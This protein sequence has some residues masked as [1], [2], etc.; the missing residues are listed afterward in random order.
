LLDYVRL[1]EDL[2]PPHWRP[3]FGP[4]WNAG[5]ETTAYFLAWIE[6]KFG[7]DKIKLLN[8]K[9]NTEKYND[10][11][12]QGLV[13]V[14]ITE[15][16]ATYCESMDEAAATDWS[17]ELSE[18]LNATAPLPGWP[19]PKLSIKVVDLAHEGVSVFF[20]AVNPKQALEEA[21]LA[22]FETLYTLSNVPTKYV[23]ELSSLYC[24][25]ILNLSGQCEG[26]SSC[27]SVYGWC[28]PH[29]GELVA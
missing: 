24:I 11:I 9:L 10:S 5:Y 25:L 26:D 4:N 16:W 20:G 7:A 3:S 23:F 8:Q 13:G 19:M 2:G 29:H 18:A 17:S 15:L 14:P 27:S 22:S 21:V 1:K 28:C 12:I 6:S